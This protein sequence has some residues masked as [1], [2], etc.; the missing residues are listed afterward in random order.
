M[1]KDLLK[2]AAALLG[3]GLVVALVVMKFPETGPVV[4]DWAK[5]AAQSCLGGLGSIASTL[6]LWHL[7]DKHKFA[8][9]KISVTNRKGKVLVKSLPAEVVKRWSADNYSDFGGFRD[10]TGSINRWED[11]GMVTVDADSAKS[12]GALTIDRS[13]KV[14]SFDYTK[15]PA[16]PART[17]Q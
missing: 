14:L 1:I 10:L 17:Q 9:W 15:L 6:L 13:A 7:H 4:Q 12:L 8:G 11:C 3:L 2:F 16:A 5:Q